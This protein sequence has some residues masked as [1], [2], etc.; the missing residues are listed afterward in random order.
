[1]DNFT[2]ELTDYLVAN[3]LA[4]KEEQIGAITGLFHKYNK[5]PE[6]CVVITKEQLDSVMSANAEMAADISETASALHVL[7]DRYKLF[8]KLQKLNPQMGQTGIL[9]TLG[10][11]FLTIMRDKNREQIFGRITNVALKYANITKKTTNGS[12]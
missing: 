10:P 9:V 8:S 7:Q 12:N 6:G 1:M 4:T 3:P 2:T 11:V 5:P